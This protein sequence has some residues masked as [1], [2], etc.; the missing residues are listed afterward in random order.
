VVKLSKKSA[1]IAFGGPME[2]LTNLKMNLR[3][4]Y[5]ELTVKDFYGKVMDRLGENRYNYLVR[6]T[7]IPP[8]VVSYF[9]A[10]QQHAVKPSAS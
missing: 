3:N 9:Q 8:E 6:F 2:L 1:E 5:E 4:V 7:S 10:H